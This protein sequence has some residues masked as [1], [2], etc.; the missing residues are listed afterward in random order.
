MRLWAALFF[1][2][3]LIVNGFGHGLSR[4]QTTLPDFSELG[5]TGDLAAFLCISPNGNGPKSGQTEGCDNC[6]L[7]V[8]AALPAAPKTPAEILAAEYSATPQLE[9]WQLPSPITR[10]PPSLRGPPLP[11]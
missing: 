11:V 10:S 2:L 9:D 1:L 6:R 8:A 7:V 3:A 4:S 5:F